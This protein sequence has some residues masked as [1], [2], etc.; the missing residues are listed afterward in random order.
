MHWQKH[1][2]I[3]FAFFAIVFTTSF[4]F[5]FH[6]V[7]DVGGWFE[8][9]FNSRVEWIGKLLN[10]KNDSDLMYHSGEDSIGMMINTINIVVFSVLLYVAIFIYWKQKLF[11][12][13]P[14]VKIYLRYYLALMLLIYGF[15]KVYKYQFYYPEPNILYTDFK[16][17][18]QDLRYWSVMGTSYVYSL[19]AGLIEVIPGVLLLWRRTYLI[20]ATVACF[21]FLNV[22]MSNLGFDITMKIFSFFLLLMSVVLLLPKLKY[23]WKV[24]SG[25][26]TEFPEDDSPVLYSKSYY[27]FLKVVVLLVFCYESQYKLIASGSINDDYSERPNL[28]G[29]YQV[30][31]DAQN[32][33]NMI[34]FHRQGYF[35]VEDNE[36][37]FYDFKLNVDRE[38]HV[39]QLTT[40]EYDKKIL[41][42]ELN[43]DTLII[44]DSVNGFHVKAIKVY[45]YNP[46]ELN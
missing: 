38:A 40:Y 15:D 45:T 14:Y 43:Q 37:L 34:Y 12:L 22:F 23:L 32:N 28:H 17:I 25:R 8:P 7:P 26:K 41:E 24:F 3:W 39:L 36:G 6:V 20:G 29:A 2:Q 18:P 33:W 13:L 10:I 19:F 21:V 35:I 5:P 44:E 4:S 16:D 9:F 30:L 1:I 27:K 31:N 42:Y 11:I 46:Y